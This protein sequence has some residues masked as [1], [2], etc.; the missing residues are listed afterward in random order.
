MAVL[1]KAA[2]ATA[3]MNWEVA[4]VIVAEMKDAHARA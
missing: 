4:E 3:G 2:V 1:L